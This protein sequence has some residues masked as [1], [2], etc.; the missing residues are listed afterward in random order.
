MISVKSGGGAAKQE[1]TVTAGTSPIEVTPN[2][3][4]LFSK[5]TVNPTPTQSKTIEP[6]PRQQVVLPDEGYHLEEVIVEASKI[7][8]VNGK[9]IRAVCLED[10]PVNSF[11][12]KVQIGS[13]KTVIG[14][15]SI[16]EA[17][18][19]RLKRIKGDYY[20]LVSKK[21]YYF[22]VTLVH[23]PVNGPVTYG[24]GTYMW[25]VGEDLG[26][27]DI[28][29]N[30]ENSFILACEAWGS[31]ATKYC[32]VDYDTMTITEK[33]SLYGET[34]GYNPCIIKISNNRFM[35]LISANG[36]D[37]VQILAI[38]GETL[39]TELTTEIPNFYGFA[40]GYPLY[41]RENEV[42]FVCYKDE[43]ITFRSAKYSGGN[44]TFG[45]SV[46]TGASK[47]KTVYPYDII[48]Y[49]NPKKFDIFLNTGNYVYAL[50]VRNN[51]VTVLGYEALPYKISGLGD[52]DP[53]MW[54]SGDDSVYF[55]TYNALS[56]YKLSN[57]DPY[58]TL[59]SYTN[60]SAANTGCAIG[61]DIS[62]QFGV[63]FRIGVDNQIEQMVSYTGT[64]DVVI[65]G[66]LSNIYGIAT[67]E[68]LAGEEIS[69]VVMDI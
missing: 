1:K 8:I 25:Y 11:V 18:C 19:N 64:L 31:Y 14:Q 36:S 28:S 7:D 5:V 17:S 35:R 27:V 43:F 24:T 10:I 39:L 45:T 33:S 38:S 2:T 29:I 12:N 13:D 55:N 63:I 3:G 6:I 68:G 54:T 15:I 30:D 69:C 22:Y 50:N 65:P 59:E 51:V 40:Y 66:R 44:L 26:N 41:I 16:E 62:P 58:I 61:H 52:A 42:L 53:S 37:K 4:R 49:A 56:R 48:S 57:Q 21:G 34:Y 46:S 32:S 20:L 23:M 67:S 9:E 60:Q 47:D